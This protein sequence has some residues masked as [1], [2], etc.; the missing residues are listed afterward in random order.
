MPEEQKTQNQPM[1][2]TMSP[3]DQ[4]RLAAAEKLDTEDFLRVRLLNRNIELLETQ[5]ENI[6]LKHQQAMLVLQE[7]GIH[8]K[9]RYGLVDI[10]QIDPNTGAITREG[11][12]VKEPTDA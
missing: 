8:L 7:F 11:V 4:E 10:G 9:K 12:V 3:E 5:S 1:A 6:Q 2:T